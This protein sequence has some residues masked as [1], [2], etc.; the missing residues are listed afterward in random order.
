MN[1]SGSQSDGMSYHEREGRAME[2]EAAGHTAPIF[3][4]QGD[5][6]WYSVPFLLFIWFMTPALG[7]VLPTFR[8]EPLTSINS[9]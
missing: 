9:F 2:L 4:R 3:R 8:M 5:G 6:C 1:D 7:M